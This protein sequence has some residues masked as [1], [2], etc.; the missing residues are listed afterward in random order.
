VGKEAVASFRPHLLRYLRPRSRSQ[1]HP[2]DFPVSMRSR[3]G[4]YEA[5]RRTFRPM[6]T[7]VLA[8]DVRRSSRYGFAPGFAFIAVTE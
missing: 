4:R 2:G 7:A 8:M 1:S 3:A 5:G 6:F